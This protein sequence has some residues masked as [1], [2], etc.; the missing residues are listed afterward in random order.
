MAP[1]VRMASASLQ[2]P[3]AEIVSAASTDRYGVHA[4]VSRTCSVVFLRNKLVPNPLPQTVSKRFRDADAPVE[5]CPASLERI[6]TTSW[7]VVAVS[8]ALRLFGSASALANAARTFWW[9]EASV[10]ASPATRAVSYT[11]LTLPTKRIV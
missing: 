7:G 5:R 11:H 1:D 9:A 6:D 2:R 3:L 8:R 4:Q 10:A